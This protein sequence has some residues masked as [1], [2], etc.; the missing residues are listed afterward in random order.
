MILWL[1]NRAALI[2]DNQIDF[3]SATLIAGP[4]EIEATS[5]QW[6]KE[7]IKQPQYSFQ[8]Y[9][10]LKVRLLKSFA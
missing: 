7:K 3:A 5:T 9:A 2:F 6:E 4:M 8:E 10:W 1:A